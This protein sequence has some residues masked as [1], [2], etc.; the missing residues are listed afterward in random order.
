MGDNTSR[1]RTSVLFVLAALAA[2]G[3]FSTDMYLPGFPAIAHDLKT[4]VSRI[5]LTLTSYLIG[6][7]LGQLVFGPILDRFGRKKPLM[8][9]LAM[10]IVASLGCALSPSLE[11]LILLRFL[12]ATGA[13]VGMVGSRSVVRDLFSGTEMARSLSLLMMIFG[14]APIIA[15]GI[16]GI[17]V[18]SLGWRWVFGLLAVVAALVLFFVGLVLEETHGPDASVSL[19][20]DRVVLGFLS[21]FK[22][23]MFVLNAIAVGAVSGVIFAY[24]SGGPFVVIDL[25]GFTVIQSSWIFAAYGLASILGNQLNRLLLK[26]RESASVLLA[27]TVVQSFAGLLLVGA[28]LMGSVSPLIY[29]TLLFVII[30][31][32]GLIAPNGTA[33][34]LE[35][36]SRNAGSASA[37]IGCIQMAAGAFTAALVSRLHNGTTLPMAFVISGCALI[38][39]VMSMS[40]TIA[41]GA[42]GRKE[43]QVG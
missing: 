31:C 24:L 1:Q 9:G 41:E 40:D 12:L 29:L 25:F 16:G 18:S 28:S 33:R 8:V 39:L 30:F 15:P 17:V 37:L 38:A 27:M 10:Y 34:A 32:F 36:F 43:R 2:I 23:R 19:R 11:G 35:R 5:G 20:L 22:E 4:D 13:C 6:I 21:V 14:V 42:L 7:S 26:T 3:P